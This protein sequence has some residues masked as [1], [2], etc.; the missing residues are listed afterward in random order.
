MEVFDFLVSRTGFDDIA[1]VA[2]AA[3]PEAIIDVAIRLDVRHFRQERWRLAPHENQG[4]LGNGLLDCIEDVADVVFQFGRIGQ[5][6]VLF[7][8]LLGISYQ[9]EHGLQRSGRSPH[10]S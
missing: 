8:L 7:I 9:R 1:I 5:E 10:I 3:L 6:L 2:T 4:T